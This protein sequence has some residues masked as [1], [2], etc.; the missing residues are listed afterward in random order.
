MSKKCII[1]FSNSSG[2]YMKAQARLGE[3]L[4]D[5][6]AGDFLGYIGES[7]I[8]SPLHAEN[9]YAFKVYAFLAAM[10]AGYTQ[11]LW[12]DSSCY[13]IKNVQPIF[14]KIEADGYF[15]QEIGHHIG[16]WT[17][18]FTL[19]YFGLTR[20]EA[21]EMQ[22]FSCG[23]YF[24]LNFE[25]PIAKG[26]LEMW[27]AAMEAGCFIGA[28]D[29]RG[30][31]ESQDERCKGHRHDLSCGSIIANKLGMTGVPGNEWF[32]YAGPEDVVNNDTIIFKL[33]G[34]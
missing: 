29:N 32:Q 6:F 16:T 31:T 28:W 14:D 21:M 17:N 25:K 15:M 7:T 2:N 27:A 10:E 26:F 13:A 34:M 22:C 19:N 3:S 23:G 11:I 4:K 1:S 9:P 12:V 5:N 30:K 8:G 20:D 24:G 33:Q 18:D